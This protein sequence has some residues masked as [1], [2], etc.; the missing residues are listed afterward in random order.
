MAG[1]FQLLELKNEHGASGKSISLG[2][3]VRVAEHTSILPVTSECLS[4]GALTK[5][6]KA[7][8]KELEDALERAKGLFEGRGSSGGM[9]ITD[10][11]LPEQVWSVLSAISGDGPFVESFNSMAEDRRREVA[12]YILTSCNIF[13]GK[14][15]VFSAR[16]DSDTALV[17]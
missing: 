10:D 6:V 12:E 17:E 14:A 1:M 11:M 8:Q 5:E 15:A 9:G 4:V 3:Q 7:L 13:A 16:Y 2:I